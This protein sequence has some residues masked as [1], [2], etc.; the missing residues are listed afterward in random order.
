M[1][2]CCIKLQNEVNDLE[3]KIKNLKHYILGNNDDH[4]QS[5]N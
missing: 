2:F 5:N 1:T 4:N 3:I